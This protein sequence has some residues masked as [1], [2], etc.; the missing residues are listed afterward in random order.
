MQASAV[1]SS[2]VR[3]IVSGESIQRLLALGALVILLVFF[4]IVVPNFANKSTTQ[5]P[6]IWSAAG[7][8]TTVKYKQGNLP[9]TIKSQNRVVGQ[10]LPCDTTDVT[11]SKN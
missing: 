7:F 5:A 11:V 8:T 1:A 10:S 9:W 4:S 6:G 3:S 2:R